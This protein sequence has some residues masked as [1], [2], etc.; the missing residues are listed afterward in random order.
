[1][2]KHDK[3]RYIEAARRII[4]FRFLTDEE[5]LDLLDVSEIRTFG[6][7]EILVSE[8]DIS[9]YFFGIIEGSVSISVMESEGKSVYVDTLGPGDVFGE[10]GI[11][12]KV[13][14]TAT[15]AAL[16]DVQAIMIHRKDL[17]RFI[18]TQPEAGNKILLVII[19][20]LLRKLR[21]VNQELAYE[22][23]S[24]IAQDDI[25][26]MVDDLFGDKDQ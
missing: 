5:I 19:Y 2:S 1:M 9:P 14:R 15:V 11:F 3:G 7:E 23:R 21:K 10:A 8:G 25:D 17:V 24:D 26:A 22:R 6:T 4:S 20:S 13:K 16:G 12:M 18:K